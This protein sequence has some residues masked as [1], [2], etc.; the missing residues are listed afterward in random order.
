MLAETLRFL[1]VGALL[2]ILPGFLLLQA[3]LP[4]GRAS[5]RGPER[6]FLTIVGGF[7]V[8]TLVGLVLG[9]LPHKPGEDGHYSTLATGA[10]TVEIVLLLVCGLLFY[11]G[12]ARGAYPRL[13]ARFPQLVPG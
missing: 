1:L 9:F 2:V 7:V 4:P 13:T 8:V 10:P 6:A 3:L 11:V 5:L 12:L